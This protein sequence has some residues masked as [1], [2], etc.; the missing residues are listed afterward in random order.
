ML[1]ESDADLSYQ[2]LPETR[3]QWVEPYILTDELY[4]K[5]WEEQLFKTNTFAPE[6]KIYETKKGEKVRS[7]SEAIIADILSGLSFMRWCRFAMYNGRS[8][9]AAFDRPDDTDLY[10]RWPLM[11]HSRRLFR[12]A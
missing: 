9:I 4:A 2:M 1:E 7:K 11:V 8:D 3:K 5:R 6:A 12:K 10:G